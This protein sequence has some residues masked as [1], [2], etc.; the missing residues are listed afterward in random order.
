V[1]D[2]VTELGA[3][4][5]LKVTQQVKVPRV[6]GP[7]VRT[8]KGHHAKGIGASALRAGGNVSGIAGTAAA[9]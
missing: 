9:D 6:E 3:V 2:R 1:L 8:T 7:M 5:R 4:A